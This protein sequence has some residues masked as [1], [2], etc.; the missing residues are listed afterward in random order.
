MEDLFTFKISPDLD[1]GN[2]IISN[3][4]VA[5][6]V[7]FTLS[8][9]GVTLST[10]A[11]VLV[12]ATAVLFAQWRQN[13]KN[14]LLMQ[15]MLAR[16][17]FTMA[18]YFYDVT[19]VLEINVTP[20]FFT[21]LDLLILFYTEMVLLA[22]MTV[23]TKQMYDNL[24]KLFVVGHPPLW[25]ISLATWLIPSFCATGFFVLFVLRFRKLFL[26]LVYLLILKL[27]VLVIIAVLLIKTI[28]SIVTVNKSKTESNSRIVIVMVA[29]IFM[30]CIQQVIIDTYKVVAV[31]IVNRMNELP[32]II[33]TTLVIFNIFAIYHCAL[34]IFFWLFGNSQTRKLWKFKS[35][36]EASQNC[37]S[38][39][40]STK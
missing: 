28:K 3:R 15:F 37:L 31:I 38:L 40:I 14:Q 17:L 11:L 8:T 26:Y 2:V 19:R 39:R 6:I 5:T 30:F 13:Y 34:S 4:T 16:F 24:V 1:N 21:H 9:I 33:H 27:P 29:L 35:K 32:D 10:V 7:T 23:F 22:W 25:K 12:I 18:R 36:H 20:A